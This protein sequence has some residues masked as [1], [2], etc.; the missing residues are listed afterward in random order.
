MKITWKITGSMLLLGLLCGVCA[1][2]ILIFGF[3]ELN[4]LYHGDDSMGIDEW[5]LLFGLGGLLLGFALTVLVLFRIVWRVVIPLRRGAEFADLLAANELPDRLPEV[6]SVNDEVRK[7]YTALNL[8]RD[9][10]LSLS[11]KLKLSMKREAEIR[12]VAENH[13]LLQLKIISRI[14]PE[15]RIPLGAIKGFSRIALLDLGSPEPDRTELTRLL[16]ETGH[17]V[18]VMSR[19]IERISDLAK[20]DLARWEHVET[21]EFDTAEFMRELLTF[22]QIP[23]QEREVMLVNHFSASAPARMVLD[24]ELLHQLLSIMIIAVG[25]VASP[26]E[27]LVFS[28]FLEENKVIFEVK[29]S[30]HA[31]LREP[32]TELFLSFAKSK[33]STDFE[34]ENLSIPILGLVF[35]N[36]LAV[37]LGGVMNVYSTEQAN[38]V[39]RFEISDRYIAQKGESRLA[40][41]V[42]P[43]Q[44]HSKAKE[45]KAVAVTGKKI[46]VLY[47]GDD[48]DAPLM[49]RRLLENQKIEVDSCANIDELHDRLKS[50]SY[51]FVILSRLRLHCDFLMLIEDLRRNTGRRD[52][53]IAV[54]DIAFSEEFQRE[55]TKLGRVYLMNIPINYA[56]LGRLIREAV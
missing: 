32:L 50:N 13:S 12:R 23:L 19:Q 40:H 53:P 48:P 18:G 49:F 31:T 28:C 35:A 4:A 47:C 37:R 2:P 11:S 9:K 55:L 39:L 36:D 38:A 16:E 54:I 14:V 45:T 6:G 8:L 46:R 27:T 10:Q 29:D 56:L 51:D 41:G 1:I 33:D 34:V 22:N 25:R 26:G 43:R 30:K 15:M 24:R 3:P 52:L 20:L 5:L 44:T 17:R 42:K 7:L 21:V